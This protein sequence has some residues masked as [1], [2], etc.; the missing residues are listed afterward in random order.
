MT[1]PVGTAE[2]AANLALGHLGIPEI[3]SMSDK[4]TRARCMRKFFDLARDELLRE[5]PWNFATAWVTPARDPV[6]GQGDLK[7][8]YPLP[9]DCLRVRYIKGDNRREWA[10]E[11]GEAGVGGV[12]VEA[13]VLVTNIVSPTVCYTKRVTA[14][15]LWDPI[16]LSG[17]GHLLASYAATQLGRSQS[18]AEA[19][20][21]LA[22]HR[23]GTAATIDA[24]EK[25]SSQCARPETSWVT[26]RRGG[27][28][29][30]R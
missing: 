14:V 17:F 16:F 3:A 7:L 2:Y 8:R 28:R 5:K 25:Q 11:G 29:L 19:Q 13:V 20:R 22:M 18:W 1:A 9:D 30:Y 4:T 26:V 23:I 24:K 12:P 21:A 6:P 27:G 15:R 10:V